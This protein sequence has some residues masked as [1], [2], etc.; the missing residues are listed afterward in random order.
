LEAPLE[1]L[2]SF[3]HAVYPLGCTCDFGCAA[4][5]RRAWGRGDAVAFLASDEAAF[6]TGQVLSVSG[7][8]TMHG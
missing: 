3:S 8:L 7:G 6:I 2:M 4:A 1:K 5:H